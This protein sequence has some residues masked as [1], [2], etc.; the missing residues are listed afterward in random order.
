[1]ETKKSRKQRKQEKKGQRQS[2]VGADPGRRTADQTVDQTIQAALDNMLQVIKGRFEDMK[3][4]NLESLQKAVEQVNQRREAQNK[5]VK[6]LVK[7][8]AE[9]ADSQMI[10]AIEI[11]RLKERQRRMRDIIEGLEKRAGRQ[12]L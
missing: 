11:D 2:G 8:V 4:D 7:A 12:K 10:A 9:Q 6:E 5:K 1:M 3:R